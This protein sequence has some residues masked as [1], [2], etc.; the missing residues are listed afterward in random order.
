MGLLEIKIVGQIE[1]PDRY[2]LVNEALI[3]LGGKVGSNGNVYL[4]LDITPMA[5]EVIA[6][7]N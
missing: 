2:K 1:F 3:E 7:G 6:T 4:A 5:Q